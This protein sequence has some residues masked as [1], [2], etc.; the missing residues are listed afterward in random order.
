MARRGRLSAASIRPYNSRIMGDIAAEHLEAL[1][2][3][4]RDDQ[5]STKPAVLD[6]HSRDE[7]SYAPAAPTAVVFAESAED[8][9]GVVS[10]C[11]EMRVPV[12]PWG[13]GTSLEANPMA[14][15][16]GITLD[17]SRM[18]GIVDVRPDD[19][20]VTVGPGVDHTV[21]NERLSRHGLFFPPDPGAPCTIAGMAANNAAGIRGFKY[22]ATRQ[23]VLELEVVLA[24]GEAIR[25][26]TRAMR[27]SSGYDLVRLF[28]GSEGTL[29]VLTEITLK[30]AGLPPEVSA[31]TASFPSLA[32]A[33]QAV[34]DLVQAGLA[35]TALELMD[36]VAV[37]QINAF[38]G[39]D[40]PEGP[41]LFL[42]FS[43]TE[44]AVAEDVELAQSVC[45]DH[46]CT[47]YQHA[48]GRKERDRLWDARH[49][50][51]YAAA[52]DNPDKRSI[53]TDV[54]VPI[55]RLPALI[56]F[57]QEE[58]TNHG[59]RGPIHAHAG[60][61][62]F[63]VVVFYDDDAEADAH[64]YNRSL[65]TKALSVGGTATGE[66]GVGS[67][68]ISF[69]EAEHGASYAWMGRVKD[70]F[71]PNGILNPGKIFA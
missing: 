18:N 11:N 46:R 32:D 22:G 1:R 69:M 9:A 5:I 45:G 59:L 47:R 57:A 65:V 35:P 39:L 15:Q 64:A 44:P 54:A 52:A 27:S 41:L 14:L 68:K 53:I 24:H 61:G 48:L 56:D 28:V 2:S 37:R 63:H 19:L 70:L 36:P 16:G 33:S 58:L 10:Y 34:V 50:A 31:A 4:L 43:G 13:A 23:W 55:S 71:D 40:L 12:T 25:C 3:R 62:N 51:Y 30:L 38:K 17:C 8:V 20:Q 49:E 60:D 21:L 7:S 29:G 67:G 66:H 6:E 42:E 26:G